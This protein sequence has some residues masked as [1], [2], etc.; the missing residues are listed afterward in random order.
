[1]N[2]ARLFILLVASV[3]IKIIPAL[4]ARFTAAMTL[5]GT[6]LR[7]LPASTNIQL[8]SYQLRVSSTDDGTV[9]HELFL[10]EGSGNYASTATLDYPGSDALGARI[11]DLSLD[12][13]L[14]GDLDVNGVT[15]FREVDR[16]VIALASSGILIVD[17]GMDTMTAPIQ[18]LWN[19]AAGSASGTVDLRL[20]LSDF[21]LP[22][23]TF[24]HAFEIF[25]YRGPLT[26]EVIGPIIKAEINLLRRGGAG[27]FAGPFNLGQIGTIG[28]SYSSTVWTSPDQTSFK[29]LGS[30]QVPELDLS[31]NRI[32]KELFLGVLVFE[33]G[34]P[35]TPTQDEYDIFEVVIRDTEDSD[36]DGI[37][38]LGDSPFLE[39]KPASIEILR[40]NSGLAVRINGQPE[41]RWTVERA[42]T[43]NGVWS[44]PLQVT[45]NAAGTFE[46]PSET[47][48]EG[49]VFFRARTP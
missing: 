16:A 39:S 2:L 15:D 47:A 7:L 32:G 46:L 21:G 38:N 22:T 3:T 27:G 25:E 17:D 19:R 34:N 49:P 6:S 29:V 4:P 18:A 24:R 48:R 8:Q 10:N 44:S 36:K 40:K 35:S 11:G 12:I 14:S 1:M 5:S 42:F 45:L 37:P 26:Y 9:N 23:V 43:L 33:D 28:L 31:F 13:P 41:E 30:T 20:D